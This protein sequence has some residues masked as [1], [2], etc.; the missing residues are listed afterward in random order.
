FE[1]QSVTGVIDF[2]EVLAGVHAAPIEAQLIFAVARGLIIE[3]IGGAVAVRPFLEGAVDENRKEIRV[4]G[5][6]VGEARH[7]RGGAILWESNRLAVGAGKCDLKR[8]R[9][10]SAGG[11]AGE[12]AEVAWESSRAGFLEPDGDRR[13]AARRDG[14]VGES[15]LTRQARVLA[16]E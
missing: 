5:E 10:R 8:L 15:K 12:R 4:G 2:D 14:E 16:V 1:C 6:R 9:R 7:D 11:R 13:I 3:D